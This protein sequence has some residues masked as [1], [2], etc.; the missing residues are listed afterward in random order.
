MDAVH[1]ITNRQHELGLEA[2]KSWTAFLRLLC[3]HC[4]PEGAESRRL[5]Y[6]DTLRVFLPELYDRSRRV[7]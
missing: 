6:I 1:T 7:R 5:Y 4:T 2:L 3:M